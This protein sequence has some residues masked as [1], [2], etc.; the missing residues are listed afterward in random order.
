MGRQVSVILDCASCSFVWQVAGNGRL[1][2]LRGRCCT[3]T[4]YLADVE[5]RVL[6]RF[7]LIVCG[8][9]VQRL[10]QVGL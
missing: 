7:L 4:K 9:R 10:V 8:A 1:R 3:K 6:V 2:R 5:R